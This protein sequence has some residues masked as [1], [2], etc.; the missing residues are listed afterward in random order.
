M[1]HRSSLAT[2]VVAVTLVAGALPALA[3]PSPAP[4]PPAAPGGALTAGAGAP[5]AARPPPPPPPP[6]RPRAPAV[7]GEPPPPGDAPA[8]QRHRPGGRKRQRGARGQH[9]VG[10]GA[11]LPRTAGARRRTGRRTDAGGGAP[12]ARG[13]LVAGDP[14]HLR[15]RHPRL[16]RSPLVGPRGR[17]GAG[18]RPGR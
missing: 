17:P 11:Q 13:R 12:P 10:G 6:A 8:H 15:Q 7:R 3:A 16:R 9:A 1:R 5:P 18:A 14:R 4:T 2:L